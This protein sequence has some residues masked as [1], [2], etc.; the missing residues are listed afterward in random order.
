LLL[1]I[2]IAL[3]IIDSEYFVSSNRMCAKYGI[4]ARCV[5][6]IKNEWA[7]GMVVKLGLLRRLLNYGDR[8]F[9]A[10]GQW[11]GSMEN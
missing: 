5:Y 11:A 8:V 9:S 6:E 7:T 4:I 10:S 3:A 2:I 1:L